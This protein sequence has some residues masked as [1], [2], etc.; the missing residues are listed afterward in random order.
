MEGVVAQRPDL[1]DAYEVWPRATAVLEAM[2]IATPADTVIATGKGH[3]TAQE[4]G[5]VF[6]PYTDAGAFRDA[7]V[8]LATE[9][10]REER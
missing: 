8:A 7:L 1:H 4:I 6:Y 10:K 9:P 2:R 5:T 3:E